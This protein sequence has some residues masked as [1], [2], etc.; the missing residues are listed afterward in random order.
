MDLFM[1]SIFKSV[2]LF[3][4]KSHMDFIIMALSYGLA[5]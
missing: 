4:Y 5:N 2:C 1:D 3:L